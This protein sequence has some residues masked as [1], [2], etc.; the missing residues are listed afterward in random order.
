M[1]I[2][3]LLATAAV[4]AAPFAGVAGAANSTGYLEGTQF[5][6][7]GKGFKKRFKKKGGGKK[8]PQCFSRCISKG[9]P[10]PMCNGRC[11]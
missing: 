1:A 3:L 2:V 5:K 8:G 11:R 6:R 7:K 4:K 9:N 10:A